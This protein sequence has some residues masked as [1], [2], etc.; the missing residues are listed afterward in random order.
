LSG[1]SFARKVRNLSLPVMSVIAHPS[2]APATG[3]I[4]IDSVGSTEPRLSLPISRWEVGFR[5][6]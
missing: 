6:A 2:E 3:G 5:E 1:F 4:F